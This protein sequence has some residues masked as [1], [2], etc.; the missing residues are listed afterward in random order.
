MTLDELVWEVDN[1][2]QFPVDRYRSQKLRL[3]PGVDAG[4][5][6]HWGYQIVKRVPPHRRAGKWTIRTFEYEHTKPTQSTDHFLAE[7]EVA[8]FISGLEPMDRETWWRRLV[9]RWART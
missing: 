5:N 8:M 7:W 4:A 3:R 9:R 6:T 2:P 1:P